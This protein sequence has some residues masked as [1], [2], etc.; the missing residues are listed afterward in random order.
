MVVRIAKKESV[1]D[2]HVQ[3]D[4]SRSL[5]P[6]P[7]F[8]ATF[9]LGTFPAPVPAPEKLKARLA[10]KAI[11]AVCELADRAIAHAER[12]TPNDKPV[13]NVTFDTIDTALKNIIQAASF[14]SSHFFS[15]AS[16]GSVV[17]IPQFNVLEHL[18]APWVETAHLPMMLHAHWHEV[19]DR[20]AD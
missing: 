10:H 18:D 11:A 16:F 4:L 5:H 19:S 1:R 9:Y 13:A 8:H 14:L 6:P 15:D 2:A 7:E 12:L 20:L 17:P 3:L